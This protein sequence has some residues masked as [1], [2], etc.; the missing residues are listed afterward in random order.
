M[1]K[2]YW[3][4]ALAFLISL[5]CISQTQ[6]KKYWQA[7][8]QNDRKKALEAFETQKPS[9]N[10]ETHATE[11]ILQ[12]EDGKLSH[13]ET[14]LGKVMDDPDF[15]MYLY[16]LWNDVY[17]FDKYLE[18]G[19]NPNSVKN[20]KRISQLNFKNQTVKDAVVYINAIAHRHLND[21][22]TYDK[23]IAKMDF[24]NAWQFCGVFENLNE[25]GLDEIYEPETTAASEEGFNANSNGIVNWYTPKYQSQD[26]YTFFTN[27]QEYG[28]GV[29]YAQTFITSKEAQRVVLHV[30]NSGAFKVWMNDELLLVNTEDMQT[31]LDAYAVA[32]TLPKG[33]SRLLIKNADNSTKSYFIARLTDA[34]GI[35][36]QNVSYSSNAQVYQKGT[37]LEP[38]AVENVIEKFF[39]DK[40]AANPNNFFYDY[41]LIRLYLRN[42]NY[43][44][45]RAIIDPFLKTYPK[46]SLLRKLN[47]II[48]VLE[49][50]YNKIQEIKDNLWLDDPDYYLSLTYK[51]SD[52]KELFRMDINEMEKLLNRFAAATDVEV[53]Q[54]SA[55]LMLQMRNSDQKGAEESMNRLIEVT[56]GYPQL[57]IRY[58]PIYATILKDDNKTIKIL[59][60]LTKNH[61]EYS[62]VKQ[63]AY[64]YEKQ[65]KKDKTLKL[66]KNLYKNLKGENTIIGEIIKKL[67]KYDRHEESLPYIKELKENFPYSFV[68][69]RYAGDAYMEL[70]EKEKA[71]KAYEASLVHNM[72][73]SSLRKK[74]QDIQNQKDFLEELHEPKIYEYIQKE[75][76][77]VK[78]TLYGY[79]IL[80][81]DKDVIL[82]KEGGG[83]SRF[84]SAYD[85]LTEEGVESFKE[86]D[87]GLSGNYSVIKSEIVK[88]NG[89]VIPAE[90]RG[91]KLVFTGLEVGDVIHLDYEINFSGNGRFYKDYT[92]TFQFD[93]FVP[94]LKSSYSILAPKEQKIY[95]EIINGDITLQKR[96]KGAYDLFTWELITDE[97]L[98]EQ[99]YYM[100]Q[101]VDIA[102]HLHIS[103]IESWNDIAKWYSDLV[104]KQIDINPTV[105]EVYNELF[106]E[107]DVTKLSE[108]ERARRIYYYITNNMNYSYVS[109]RQSGFIPQKPSKT[110]KTKLGDCKDFSTLFVTLAKK[111]KLD[112]NLVL[113]LTSDYGQNTLVLPAQDFNHCIAEVKLNGET[114]FLELTD[115]DLPFKALPVSLQGATALKIP[116]DTTKEIKSDLIKLKNVKRSP[117]VYRTKAKITISDDKQVIDMDSSLEGE[118]VS[119]Y[120][121]ILRNRDYNSM[122]SDLQDDIN[123]RIGGNITIDTITNVTSKKESE[124]FKYRTVATLEQKAKKIG[125]ISVVELPHIANAYNN[126]IINFEKRNYPIEY[127]QYENVDHYIT[128]YELMIPEGKKF[129]EYPENIELSFKKHSYKI[130]FDLKKENQ[131]NVTIE[132]KVDKENNIIP[133]EYEDFKKYVAAALEGKE[134]LIGYK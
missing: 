109:F 26:G 72:E 62:A 59:E 68:A 91:S 53:F 75:R 4:F 71:V 21:F 80:L 98:P 93:A 119:F 48:L 5:N 13:D 12:V 78:E 86:Y 111:A 50:E 60:D 61:F 125:S 67:H 127:I 16:A 81:D 115:K 10:F 124:V 39:K 43:I 92:D 1:K 82:F 117:S 11:R 84:T 132:A 63:L 128:E 58:A 70:G 54:V 41:C 97:A 79:T 116:F 19:F 14:F 3:L 90:R 99:E 114:Q 69:D 56:K 123:G 77:R 29:N 108:E 94:C 7:L 32:F 30:G 27:H 107:K 44:K 87:L 106:P 89:S 110:I 15:E 9:E 46:S 28:S 6:E 42:E 45:A 96:S 23:N 121:S 38:A 37:K 105:D 49:E 113:I 40:K 22:D 83:K 130:V 122:K 20:I 66:Y 120:A 88:E 118:I 101:D 65:N 31:D 64:Y 18:I 103:T 131:L 36:I 104:R 52:A 73:N 133:E 33:T 102:R 51:F 129:I 2:V 55:N 17:F 76:G 34:N 24:I 112:T 95:Y 126:S 25:S 57:T 100:P 74:I 8:L 134:S 35:P 85:I 47:S